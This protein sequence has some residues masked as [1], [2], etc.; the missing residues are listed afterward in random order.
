[1]SAG[2][3]CVTHVT[4]YDQDAPQTD[5]S[6][7]CLLGW[8]VSSLSVF[9]FSFF[10]VFCFDWRYMPPT[11]SRTFER[12]GLASSP[13]GERS[14]FEASKISLSVFV[15]VLSYG[16]SVLFW[17]GLQRRMCLCTSE[18]PDRDS[19]IVR[20]YF[21]ALYF[22]Y[23]ST[24]TVHKNIYISRIEIKKKFIL[25]GQEYNTR[26]RNTSVCLWTDCCDR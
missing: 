23:S 22:N 1:M 17:S 2:S 13:E 15:S 10:S 9:L 18:W 7:D 4:S 14:I 11:F 20:S 6:K 19:F 12:R 26:F 3:V 16:V 24:S 8:R 21:L 5:V 25:Y